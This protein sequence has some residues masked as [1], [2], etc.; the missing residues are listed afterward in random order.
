MYESTCM[1]IVFSENYDNFKKFTDDSGNRNI[2][3][4]KKKYITNAENIK[5]I[6]SLIICYH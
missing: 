5:I 6:V 4:P 3:K 1:Q 2:K